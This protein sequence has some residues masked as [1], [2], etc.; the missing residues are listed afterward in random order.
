MGASEGA[1]L[2]SIAMPPGFSN[3]APR[4]SGPSALGGAIFGAPGDRNMAGAGAGAFRGSGVGS[5]NGGKSQQEMQTE[6]QMQAEL[7]RVK[8]ERDELERRL[9]EMEAAKASLPPPPLPSTAML[10]PAAPAA[11]GVGPAAAEEMLR[12]LESNLAVSAA[13]VNSK[14]ARARES[15][16]KPERKQDAAVK[17]RDTNSKARVGAAERDARDGC[18]VICFVLYMYRTLSLCR[19]ERFLYANTSTNTSTN[20]SISHLCHCVC[21][22]EGVGE[23]RA[24]TARKLHMVFHTHTHTNTHTQVHHPQTGGSTCPAQ[25]CIY[26]TLISTSI[27]PNHVTVQSLTRTVLSSCP[28][29]RHTRSGKHHVIKGPILSHKC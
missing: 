17:K 1:G 9:R 7:S 2:G 26:Q 15:A 14:A 4:A 27:S 24:R 13:R 10:P 21:V 3:L 6:M 12:Q 20:T 8:R 23:Q 11:A 19:R 18:F 25:R 28:P 5:L 29:T 22:S 16:V